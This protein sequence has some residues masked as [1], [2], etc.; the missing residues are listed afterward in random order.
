M[1]CTV[2]LKSVGVLPDPTGNSVAGGSHGPTKDTPGSVSTNRSRALVSVLAK[3]DRS[4]VLVNVSVKS[5]VSPTASKS[6]VTASFSSRRS[7]VPSCG[8]TALSVGETVP[9]LP[10]AKASLR[11]NPAALSALVT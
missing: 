4:P 1:R 6:A 10:V 9:S 11:T 5:T 2:Q 3:I 8:I 7:K